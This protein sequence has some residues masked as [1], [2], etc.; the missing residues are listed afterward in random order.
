MSYGSRAAERLAHKT[1]LIT[2]ASS[3]IGQATAIELA[4]AAKGDIK[5]I[6]AARRADRL[7]NL[8]KE[9]EE[10]H[11]KIQVLCKSLDVTDIAS[12]PQWVSSVPT[13]FADVDVLINNA[14][15]VFGNEKVGE[16]HQSDIETMFNTNVLG[17]IALTQQY[18]PK[19]KA[20]NSGDIVMLGSIAGR[21]PYP[22]GAIYC[23]TKAALHSFSEVIRKENID[24][25]IRVMEVQPG[26]VETEFSGKLFDIF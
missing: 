7:E 24:N 11:S 16:I 14:G 21:D 3:G 13:E 8:K 12:I 9:L 1:I 6:L 17:L 20:K 23:A 10:T 2:G 15:M 4:N 25:G 26:Q 19:F 5:L 18:V 22:G